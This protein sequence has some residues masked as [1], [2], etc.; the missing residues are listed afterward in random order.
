[1]LKT[2][3]GSGILIFKQILHGFIQQIWR[4]PP[5]ISGVLKNIGRQSDLQEKRTSDVKTGH[6][7]VMKENALGEA[8]NEC[9]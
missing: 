7:G 9:N 4:A 2:E 6:N 3:K 5:V 1:M 8:G